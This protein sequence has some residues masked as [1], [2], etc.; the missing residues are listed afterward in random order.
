[1]KF[2]EFDGSKAL[3]GYLQSTA[4]K[5]MTAVHFTTIPCE[6]NT[7]NRLKESHIFCEIRPSANNRQQGIF[8][9][10]VIFT[11][12]RAM[13]KIRGFANIVE[14]YYSVKRESQVR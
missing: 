3:Y 13:K 2:V 12:I 8:V 14:S 1:M 11:L 10:S 9:L 4:R 7:A 6:P 5:M